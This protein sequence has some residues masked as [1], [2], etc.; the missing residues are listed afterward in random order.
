MK[1]KPRRVCVL[2][3]VALN[4]VYFPSPSDVWEAF[5]FADSNAFTRSQQSFHASTYSTH[6]SCW[7]LCFAIHH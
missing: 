6:L 3:A 1:V 2:S 4:T 7:W 5:A